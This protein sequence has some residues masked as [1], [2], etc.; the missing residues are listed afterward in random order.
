MKLITGMLMLTVVLLMAG[1]VAAIGEEQEED[2]PIIA[3]GNM[4]QSM[5]LEELPFELLEV[6]PHD[7]TG[8]LEDV[9]DFVVW[10]GY[11]VDLRD[12]TLYNAFQYSAG[13]AVAVDLLEGE[14]YYS[15]ITCPEPEADEDSG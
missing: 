13:C 14:D 12:G 2:L 5:R 1:I 8:L 9:G 11:V 3:T 7:E 15:W 4:R 6:I 10:F